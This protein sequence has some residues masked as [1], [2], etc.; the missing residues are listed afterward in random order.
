VVAEPRRALLIPGFA[1]VKAAALAAGALG[2]S[3]SGSGPSMFALCA[4]QEAAWTA[5]KAM[6]ETFRR[7]GLECDLYVSAINRVGPVCLQRG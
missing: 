3:I 7:V 2:C 6:Q 5:G 1:E 4:S